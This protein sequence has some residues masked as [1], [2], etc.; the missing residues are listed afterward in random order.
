[1]IP[2]MRNPIIY[3]VEDQPAVRFALGEMLSVLGREVQTYG[4]AGEFLLALDATRPSCLLADVRMPDMDGIEL[5]RELARR[6]VGIPAVL[7]SGYADVRMA[8]EAMKAGAEDFIEKP[9]GDELTLAI[10]RCIALAT[11]RLSGG[12]SEDDLERRFRSLS[13]SETKVFDLV[14][15]GRTCEEI[16]ATIGKSP[17][18]VEY[19]RAQIMS[20]MQAD[21]IAVLV[22]QAVRLKR[23]AA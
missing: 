18:T 22:R 19:Y 11:M 17:R 15:E 20:K 8:V 14:A 16:A 5:V 13:P 21:N 9:C 23:I 12:R 2:H 10:E 3:I 1:M 4:S 6:S 7:V